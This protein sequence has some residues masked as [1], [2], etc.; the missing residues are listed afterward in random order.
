MSF[1]EI[2]GIAVGLA[3][4]AMSV[5]I[6]T[7]LMLGRVN[8][9]QVFRFAFNFGL[10]QGAMPILGWFAGRG[11]EQYIQAWDHW[12]A[13]LLLAGIGLKAIIETLKGNE[14]VA[15]VPDPTVGVTLYVL[16][17]ATSIDAL[18][19]GLNFGILEVPVWWP[20]V[21]IAL[22][23]AGLTTAGMLL[24]RYINTNARK[25]MQIFGGLVLIGI[26]VRILIEHMI[27]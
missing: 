27:S 1:L 11:I 5:A 19:V 17:I 22:V 24:S 2:F 3:M 9:G 7:S 6:A 14:N 18:A 13:F 12:V 21:V 25:A 16:A 20:S 4:D 10:F 23:T 8:A 15:G 26:G